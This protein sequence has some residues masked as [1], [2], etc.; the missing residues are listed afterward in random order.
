MT[1]RRRPNDPIGNRLAAADCQWAKDLSDLR[2]PVDRSK[3]LLTPQTVNAYYMAT[4]NDMAYPAAYLQ[5]P[6]FNPKADA[7]V[8]YGAIGATIGHEIGHGFDDEGRRYDGTG[9]P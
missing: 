6:N 3:W 8:N 7:A 9:S 4:A 2:K 5:P 1:A